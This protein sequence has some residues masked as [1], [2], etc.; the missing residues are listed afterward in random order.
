MAGSEA[1]AARISAP[2]AASSAATSAPRTG[3]PAPFD[4]APEQRLE[5]L[6]RVDEQHWAA[7]WDGHPA[8]AQWLADRYDGSA[9][10]EER[11]GVRS[12][13]L[14]DRHSARL[15]PLLAVAPRTGAWWA[16][17]PR[18]PGVPLPRLRALCELSPRQA[19]AVGLSVLHAVQ[20]LHAR[21][22]WH[23]RLAGAADDVVVAPDGRARLGGWAAG[24][25]LLD[26]PADALRRDDLLAVRALA[27]D[28]LAQTRPGGVWSTERRDAEAEAVA[29]AG[30]ERADDDHAPD[31][32]HPVAQVLEQRLAALVG[33]PDLAERT[34][35]ELVALVRAV[36]AATDLEPEPVGDEDA[37]APAGAPAA[38]R[39]RRGR[40][41]PRRP[42]GRTA[43]P[44]RTGAT[45]PRTDRGSWLW[46]A[47]V[48]LTVL[49]VVVGLELGLLG[50]R[51]ANDL[52]VLRSPAPSAAPS[53]ATN[54]VSAALPS[55]GASTAG[56]V[57]KVDA[58]AVGACAPGRPCTLRVVV[59]VERQQRALP[60]RWSVVAVDRCTSRRSTLPGG[61]LTV[62]AGGTTAA[63]LQTVTLPKGR[64]LAVGAVT[65]AP[66]R[67]ASKPLPAPAR[68][69]TC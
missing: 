66:A 1:A 60:V 37:G 8:A 39:R 9:L 6:A 33:G 53:T 65:T 61:S 16:V 44:R 14:L 15:V 28:L 32:P 52:R 40:R 47:I 35:L 31:A 43:V 4:V 41:H 42:A 57:A 18:T 46:K 29:H 10:D 56:V 49:A 24:T 51:I 11:V 21:G 25:L 38:P 50:G 7:R 13:D 63:A 19:A 69:P 36:P 54:A 59:Q 45:A 55:L 22:W 68:P 26:G 20:D 48:A 17:W 58:R 30:E 2:P 5:L 27:A 62:P 23:G 67:A 64:A 34:R 12:R 3:T